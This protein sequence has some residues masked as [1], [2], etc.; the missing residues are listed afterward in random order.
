MCICRPGYEVSTPTTCVGKKKFSHNIL[1]TG[2]RE[3]CKRENNIII[4]C[5]FLV[6]TERFSSGENAELPV[7]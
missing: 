2:L 6:G 1:F 5:S 4:F 7:L 3:R